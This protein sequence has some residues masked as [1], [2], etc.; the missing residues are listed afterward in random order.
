[1]QKTDD[2]IFVFFTDRIAGHA[3]TESD[4]DVFCKGILKIQADHIRTRDHDLTGMTFRKIKDIIKIG[5]FGFI[6]IT[7]FIAFFH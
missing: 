7:I 5:Q 6:D 3:L 4:F 1:M 2:M